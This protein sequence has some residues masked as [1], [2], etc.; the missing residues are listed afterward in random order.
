MTDAAMMKSIDKPRYLCDSLF[1]FPK[2]PI[3]DNGSKG[4]GKPL[5]EVIDLCPPQKWLCFCIQ[6][7]ASEEEERGFI[8]HPCDSFEAV[9]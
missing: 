5:S 2:D 7:N 3:R 6:T 9:H 4:H 8:I 1:A